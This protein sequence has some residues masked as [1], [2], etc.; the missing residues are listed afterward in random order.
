MINCIIAF[1]QALQAKQPAKESASA[2]HSRLF[3][4]LP[5][6]ESLLAANCF[7]I[8]ITLERNLYIVNVLFLKVVKS[9]F[10]GGAE[11]E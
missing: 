9:S 7:I 5:Q 10:F 4:Q 3:S 2:G 6:M 1:E 8:V 11:T